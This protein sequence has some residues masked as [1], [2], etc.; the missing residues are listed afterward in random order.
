MNYDSQKLMDEINKD[1]PFEDKIIITNLTESKGVTRYKRTQPNKKYE[2]GDA[3][4]TELRW[5][6]L[7]NHE[8]LAEVEIKMIKANYNQEL[9][10]KLNNK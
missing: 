3:M 2:E 6:W 5:C 7:D 9:F 4:P 10:D 8:T 1:L